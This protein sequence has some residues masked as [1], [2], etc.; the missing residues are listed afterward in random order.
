LIDRELHAKISEHVLHII[1]AYHERRTSSTLYELQ[2]LQYKLK[3]NV[4][5]MYF[6]EYNST[7][8]LNI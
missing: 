8:I 1:N 3:Y 5:T 2:R 7:V 4:L 6:V